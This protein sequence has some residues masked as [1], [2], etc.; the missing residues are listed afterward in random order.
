MSSNSKD[1]QLMRIEEKLDKVADHIA[2][3]NTTIAKQE[4]S[5]DEHIRRTNLLE[6]KVAPLEKH[7]SMVNGVIKFIVLLSAI[8][9]IVEVFKK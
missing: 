1:Q 9:A 6:E 8:A 3:I 7:V 5:L 2:D 4:V